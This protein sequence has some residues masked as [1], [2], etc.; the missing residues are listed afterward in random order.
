MTYDAAAA[1]YSGRA[2]SAH[3]DHRHGAVLELHVLD[4]TALAA[5]DRVQEPR[6]RRADSFLDRTQRRVTH[7]RKQAAAELRRIREQRVRQSRR[8]IANPVE[9]LLDD[10]GQPQF[11]I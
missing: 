10:F 11:G 8:A 9:A 3:Y 2:C 1:R 7:C 6:S 4:S 5:K